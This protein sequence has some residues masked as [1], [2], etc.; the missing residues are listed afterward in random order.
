[1]KPP[2]RHRNPECFGIFCVGNIVNQDIQIQIPEII[3]QFFIQRLVTSR[4]HPFVVPI[5]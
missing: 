2:F 4:S 5:N 3:T 1:M